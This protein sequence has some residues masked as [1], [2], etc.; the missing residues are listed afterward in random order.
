MSVRNYEKSEERVQMMN[1]AE[2]FSKLFSELEHC[3]RAEQKQKIEVMN[4][5]TDEIDDKNF[6]SVCTKN[7][8]DKMDKM[9]D[10]EKMTLENAIVLLKHIG[11]CSVLNEFMIDGFDYSS[12]SERFEKM[13]VEENLKKK[14]EKNEKLLIDLCEC[15]LMLCSIGIKEELLA[16]CVPCL[17]KATLKKEEN[18]ETQMEVEMILLNLSTI[19]GY[20]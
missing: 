7:L 17:L 9:I 10:E 15:Y 20:V 4:A 11:Y 5:L 3:T 16:V 8:F 13:I 2:K 14:E 18:E 19:G 12:L 1:K 6:K